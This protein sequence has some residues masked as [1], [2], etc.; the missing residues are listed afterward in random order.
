MAKTLGYHITWTTYGT[1]LQGDERR[2]VKDG[3]ILPANE[4]LLQANQKLQVQDMVK[5]SKPQREIVR[6]A[7]TKQAE[8]LKQQIY[9]LAVKSNHIHVVAE[10]VPQPIAKIVAYYKSAARLAL[11]TVGCDGKVWTAGCDKRFCFD[12]ETLERRIRYVQNHNK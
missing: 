1:W 12:K 11:K 7:I 5:L 2:Y 10:Y 9:A 8:L 4:A 3:K 6:Q